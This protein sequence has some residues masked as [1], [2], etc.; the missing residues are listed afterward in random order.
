[1]RHR[2][3]QRRTD[4]ARRGHRDKIARNNDALPP[5]VS[6]AASDKLLLAEFFGRPAQAR[7]VNLSSSI[8]LQQRRIK[9]Y[10]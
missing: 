5:L 10:F 7:F 9:I 1:M 4:D 3:A 6:A 8:P 2:S